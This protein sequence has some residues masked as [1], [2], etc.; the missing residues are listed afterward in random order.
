MQAL[1][2]LI[3]ILTPEEH[4]KAISLFL[5]TLIMALLDGIGVVSI[6]PFIMILLNPQILETNLIL[7]NIYTSMKVFGLETNLQFTFFIG[8][9]T[10]IMLIISLAF[11]AFT[12]YKQHSFTSDCEYSLSKRLVEG[13]LHQPYSWFLNRHSSDLGKTILSDIR[14]VINRC[15]SP[16]VVIISQ[17]IVAIALVTVI[18]IVHYKLAIITI[19]SFIFAYILIYKFNKNLLSQI[20]KESARANQSR[21]LILSE[22]FGAT[23]EIKIGNLE[24]NFIKLFNR[25]SANYARNQALQNMISLMPR[26]GLESLALGGV[27]LVILIFLA[28]GRNLSSFL[29]IIAVYSFACYRILPS[30]QQIYANIIE[31]RFESVT[32]DNIYSDLKNLK[33]KVI[34]VDSNFISLKRSI[35]LNNVCFSYPKEPRKI[36]KNISLTI[37]AQTTVGIV[38]STGSGKT[39]LVD[40]ILG[41]INAQEGKLEVDG[42]EINKNNVRNWQRLI[43]YVP[44]NIYIADNTIAANIAFGIEE[45]YIDQKIIERVA[46]TAN[47]NKF[48]EEELPQKYLT[49][50]GERGVRLSGGQIQRI[51]IARALYNDPK[52]LIMDEATSA[53]D[54]FTEKE[55]MKE[56]Y[57]LSQNITIIIIAHRLSTIEKCKIIFLIENGKLVGQGN[58]EELSLINK[59][60]RK[61]I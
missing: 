59:Q 1:K 29:A 21:F 45:K 57:N 30:L 56:I 44:Q 7:K 37:P 14:T 50:V 33:Q 39:T 15:I 10:F 2:K 43:G 9:C 34:Y 22:A 26:Y 31:L 28:S 4:K 25:Q 42:V 55:V 49:S 58:F 27:I 41:L 24:E 47:I 36:L 3:Y 8:V 48:I 53:L 18:V 12:L 11:K 35:T 16:M 51:G 6:M 38:G 46:K 20:G 60:F 54:S 52:V 40:I 23:K 13:Y 32:L 5:V 61:I 19:V 17:S